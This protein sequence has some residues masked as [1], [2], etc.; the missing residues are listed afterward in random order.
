MP[1]RSRMSF[2]RSVVEYFGF[3]K[4]ETR[5][6]LFILAALVLGAGIKLIEYHFYSAEPDQ[7]LFDYSKS[8]REFQERSAGFAEKNRAGAT[9]RGPGANDDRSSIS[10]R[11][12]RKS[13][14]AIQS[15]NIN[16]AS[17]DELMALPGI[18]EELSERIIL[19]RDE[20][21]LFTGVEDLKKVRG[22]GDRKF[23]QLRPYV[24]VE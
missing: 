20:H 13:A 21:G 22:I 3:T 5:V 2:T 7:R 9:D 15:V 1:L 19:Y 24:T 16:S 4:T 17:R 8:D 11:A 12:I 6:I 23:E 18:G 14:P 10:A